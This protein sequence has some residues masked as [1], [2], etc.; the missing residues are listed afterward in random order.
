MLAR[1]NVIEDIQKT[2]TWENAFAAVKQHEL[3]T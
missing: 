1:Y 3:G 2:M